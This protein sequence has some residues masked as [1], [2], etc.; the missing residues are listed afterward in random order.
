MKKLYRVAAVFLLVSALAFGGN[1]LANDPGGSGQTAGQTNTAN[2]NGNGGG[3]PAEA[4]ID[5]ADDQRLINPNMNYRERV[6]MQR[7]IQRKAAAKRNA[8]I[9]AEEQKQQAQ[10]NK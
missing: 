2:E 3:P 9:Q 8:L 6:E 10:E 4:L 1:A 5:G 7:A